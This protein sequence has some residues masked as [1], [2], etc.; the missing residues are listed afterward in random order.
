MKFSP[1]IRTGGIV[2]HLRVDCTG[3]MLTLHVNGNVLM[4]VEDAD[5]TTGQVGLVAVTHAAEG[6]DILF[7]TLAI[8]QP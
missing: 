7:D 6:S 3:S 1:N 2:N 4:Q 8:L 5:F